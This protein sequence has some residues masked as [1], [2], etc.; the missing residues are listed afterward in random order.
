MR[1]P[2]QEK[3]EQDV[4]LEGISRQSPLFP[5]KVRAARARYCRDEIEFQA[6][7]RDCPKYEQCS[8]G[9]EVYVDTQYRLAEIERES[10]TKNPAPKNPWLNFE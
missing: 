2:S 4:E 1:P 5:I 8:L 10:L 7:C 9:Q 3:F 6:E